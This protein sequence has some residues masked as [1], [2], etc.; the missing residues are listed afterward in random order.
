MVENHLPLVQFD[1]KHQA[2]QESPANH[3]QSKLNTDHYLALYKTIYLIKY[4]IKG[5]KHKVRLT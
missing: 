4:S 2:L 1:P 3:K 5:L